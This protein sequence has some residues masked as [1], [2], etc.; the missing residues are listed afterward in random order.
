M[1]GPAPVGASQ[2]TRFTRRRA[3]AGLAGCLA[4]YLALAL[5][6]LDLP[7]LHNDEAV[8]GGL[9]AGQILD[10]QPI[11][12]FRGAGLELGG[13]T[14][15]VMVQDYIGAFN[16]YLPI[17]FLAIFGHTTAAL[18]LY[19]VLLGGLTL[20]LAF[21]FARSA[22]GPGAALITGLLMAVSPSFVFWQR[23][24]VFV[25]SI[26]ASL[27]V[28]M[29]WAALAWLRTRKA[30]WAFMAGL[31]A[32]AGLYAKLLF[33]WVIVGAAGAGAVA[34]LFEAARSG[35][36]IRVLLTTLRW[37]W[38][39]GL[40][41]ALMFAAG[42]LIGLAPL[43]QYNLQ[44]G[45]TFA[46]VGDNL[47]TSYYG[48]NNAD[49]AGNLR[50]RLGQLGDV[51]SGRDH[52]SYLGGSFHNPLWPWMLGAAAAVILLHALW[53]RRAGSS[54]W[55][56]ALLAL[57]VAQSSFTVSGLFATHFAILA[58]FW[59]M[60]MGAALTLRW[61][62]INRG[63]ALE[64]FATGPRRGR[65]ATALRAVAVVMVALLWVRDA[66]STL[67]YHQ[68]LH[69]VGGTSSHSDA[70][71]RLIHVLRE[72]A[73]RPVYA[74]DWGFAPQVRM[75]TREAIV[76]Q[77]IFGY[78][79]E[80]DEGFGA[81]LDEALAQPGALFVFHAES[82]TVFPRRA[83]FE[84][85]VAAQGMEVESVALLLRR[86]TVPILEVI[87]VMRQPLPSQPALRRE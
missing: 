71:Y 5:P 59:P 68:R 10:G 81:R 31:L 21:G 3:W 11:T 63:Y 60:V 8:E 33:L 62:R 26:T 30:R 24:G 44:T 56:L 46:S 34:A 70:V 78:T 37:R 13:R 9:Q 79:W 32:G 74:M 73:G 84:A 58:P 80:P 25:T 87:R 45:G 16:V 28:G 57:A 19:A 53:T 47:N 69:L 77:E 22:L 35:G 41:A 17:P 15:P 6:Q 61:E 65:L 85:A 20:G 23:E 55:V 12:T 27:A 51:I 54:L 39:H 72:H 48:V 86:D 66:T 64:R 49:I 42:G 7:G 29:M 82:D 2:L 52:L 4:L 14:W 1:G 43:A 83:A 40:A 76:P 75:L 50:V 18:R 38:R 67:A 36:G